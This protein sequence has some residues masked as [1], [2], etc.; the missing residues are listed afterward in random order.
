M[1]G[2]GTGTPHRRTD[3]ERSVPVFGFDYLLG[4]HNA[5]NEEDDSIKILVAKCKLSKCTFAHVVRQKG[6]DPNLY[7][8]KRLTRDILCLGQQNHRQE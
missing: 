7:A 5:L 2:R 6:I 3:E 8:V 4:T 1:K